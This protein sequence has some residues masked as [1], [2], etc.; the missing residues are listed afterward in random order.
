[1]HLIF[2]NLRDIKKL[3]YISLIPILLFENKFDNYILYVRH[4]LHVFKEAGWST[5]YNDFLNMISTA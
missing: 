2:F 5:K 1:M 4:L 3:R